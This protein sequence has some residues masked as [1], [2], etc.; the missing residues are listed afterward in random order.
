[1]QMP[2]DAELEEH[3]I[4][5]M[6][7]DPE[8][9]ADIVDLL[10]P[11]LFYHARNEKI[12]EKIFSLWNEDPTTVDIIN[13]APLFSELEI[14]IE[15]ISE[16]ISSIPTAANVRYYAER[17]RD[18]AAL[19]EAV[20]VG[21]YLINAG[22]GSIRDGDQIKET[23]VKAEAKLSKISEAT[24]QVDSMLSMREIM[25]QTFEDMEKTY[26]HN[27]SGIT[28]VPSG[29]PDLDRLTSGF[30]KQDLIIVAA[31]PSVGKTTF[32]LNVARAMNLQHGISGVIFSLEQGNKSLGKRFIAAEGNVD[33]QR[34]NSGLLLEDDWSRV[35]MAISNLSVE[36]LF[37][38]EQPA[39]T[40]PEMKAKLRV[41]KRKI[42]EIGFIM[43]DYLQLMGGTGTQ[44]ERVSENS[45][46]LKNIAREFDVPVICLS[47]LSRSVE[48][49]PDKHP[50]LSDLRDS[51]NIEQDA[52][53]VAFLYRDEYYNQDTEKK[54]IIEINLAKQRNGP[55]GKIELAFL[56]NFNKF[57]SL[58]RSHIDTSQSDQYKKSGSNI[59]DMYRGKGKP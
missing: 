41:L 37:V 50:I 11:K 45:R 40:I 20:K 3:I 24:V 17:L 55:V 59:P 23:I 4:G 47:Q 53:I 29:Y 7:F 5:C 16:V 56:K 12:C 13:L 38:D 42:G 36:N 54:N 34:I 43:I 9:I 28:G 2:H 19:R 44:F 15:R 48:Q 14:S 52:D 39:I 10:N 35:T 33:S 26:Y 21:Q 8:C 6:I 18:I 46:Q 51:G 57:E 25:A 1:M 30:Q 58:D 27:D 22:D 31:R 32:A 49:R